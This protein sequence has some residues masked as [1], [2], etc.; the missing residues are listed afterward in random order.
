[1]RA[2][3]GNKEY[4]ID[5]TQKKAYQDRGFDILD[6]TGTTIAYGRGKTVPYSEHIALQEENEKLRK[7]VAEI[8][9]G[10]ASIQ[11]SGEAVQPP[12]KARK[13]EG[14]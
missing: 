8:L 14:A 1:M 4:T 6:E 3:K 2:V 13:R 10:D 11:E 7:Q 12:K 5:D 9:G